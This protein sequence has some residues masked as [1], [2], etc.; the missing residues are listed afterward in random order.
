MKEDDNVSEPESLE[1]E[2][3]IHPKLSIGDISNDFVFQTNNNLT[4]NHNNDTSYINIMSNL[5]ISQNFT[6]KSHLKSPT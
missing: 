6:P 3:S 1:E 5:Q 2:D 4:T